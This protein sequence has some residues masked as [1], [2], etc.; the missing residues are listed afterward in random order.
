MAGG[1]VLATA[2]VSVVVYT[3]L[4]VMHVA[5]CTRPLSSSRVTLHEPCLPPSANVWKSLLFFGAAWSGV[6]A[7]L[8]SGVLRAPDSQAE[9]LLASVVSWALLIGWV[10]ITLAGVLWYVLWRRG[11]KEWNVQRK[12]IQ[13]AMQGEQGVE[14][15]L[16]QEEF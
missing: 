4:F 8:V 2:S 16:V 14:L 13:D 11:G 5:W 9:A 15:Q 12:M 3:A 6:A 7:I 10:L 1:E